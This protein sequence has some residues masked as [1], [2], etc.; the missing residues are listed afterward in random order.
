MGR[1][2]GLG[3]LTPC[4]SPLHGDLV[5][6]LVF[7]PGLNRREAGLGPRGFR[8]GDVVGKPALRWGEAGRGRSAWRFMCRNEKRP[9]R[10]VATAFVDELML[11]ATTSLV[12][13]WRR[14]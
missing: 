7:K 8:A 5:A 3:G 4:R 1:G 6:A 14:L 10:V 9:P 13:C 12:C 2:V 11:Q